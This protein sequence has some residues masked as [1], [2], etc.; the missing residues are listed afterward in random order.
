MKAIVAFVTTAYALSIVLSLV[1]GLSG[2]HD[3]PLIGLAYLSMFL[4]AV[5][6]LIVNS[7]MNEAP[8]VRWDHFPLTYLPVALFLIPGILHA[9]ML[10]LFARAGPIAWQDWL[11]PQAD[12]LYHTPASRGWGTLTIYGLAERIALNAVVGLAV[13]SF[14]A[15]F[16][17]I[18]WRAWLLP[19][20]A[21]RMG[22]RRAVVATAVIWGLWHVPFQ[23][24]GI[25]H[26]DGVSAVRLALS[27]PLGIMI[28]G[29]I[30]GWLWLRTESIWVVSIA[31]GALNNWGQ[32]ALK[33]MK[34]ATGPN[35]A[36]QVARDL[37]VLGAG[38]LALLVVGIVLLWRGAAPSETPHG[39]VARP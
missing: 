4:P 33:Y 34:D 9:V 39:V 32:Y 22:A 19:R 14:L 31:H 25:Q 26:I 21:D 3:S 29:L 38:F 17:E 18:G 6:V 15:F 1:V 27:G 10:P 35:V 20:L 13:V 5:S 2:G 16:E 36:E 24:S 11:T 8:R 28:T 37:Q 7:A 23:L 12:G 30:I